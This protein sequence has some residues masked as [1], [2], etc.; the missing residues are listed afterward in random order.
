MRVVRVALIASAAVRVLLSAARSRK[1]LQDEPR[2]IA[3]YVNSVNRA[4]AVLSRP[5]STQAGNNPRALNQL[6]AFSAS[7]SNQ[8]RV[9]P[10]R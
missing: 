10:S 4:S 5:R 8:A 7:C 6:R 3:D 2:G 9:D 1:K